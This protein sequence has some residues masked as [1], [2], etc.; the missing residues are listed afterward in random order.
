MG[1]TE[2]LMSLLPGLR[3][4]RKWGILYGHEPSILSCHTPKIASVQRGAEQKGASLLVP[5]P[6]AYC[7]SLCILKSEY[8]PSMRNAGRG[9]GHL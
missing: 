9:G 8:L 4:H 3:N 5:W 6:L 7:R 2:N 1:R